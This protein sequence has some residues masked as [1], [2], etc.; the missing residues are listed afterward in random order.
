[1][2]NLGL[3]FGV[4]RREH[5]FDGTTGR[6]LDGCEGVGVTGESKFDVGVRIDDKLIFIRMGSKHDYS[7]MAMT[8]DMARTVSDL[9]LALVESVEGWTDA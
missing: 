4:T 9:L 8:P 5:C 3:V 1:M 6:V 2:V 7:E